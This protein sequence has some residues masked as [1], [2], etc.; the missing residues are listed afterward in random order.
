MLVCHRSRLLS[1][2]LVAFLAAGTAGLARAQPDSTQP[3]RSKQAA[4]FDRLYAYLDDDA[5]EFD[6][7]RWR[8][9]TA[10][11]KALIPPGDVG[12]SLRHKTLA[13]PTDFDDVKAGFAYATQALAEARAARDRA[14]EVRL[15]YCQ[16]SYRELFETPQT[17]LA[18]YEAGLALARSTGDGRLIAEGLVLRGGSYS[19]LGDQARALMDFFEAQKLF[20]RLGRRRAAEFNL[21]GIAIAYRR[22]GE[23]DKARENFEASRARS[24][25]RKDWNSLV[26]DLL[27]LG[28]VHEDLGEAD[29]ALALYREA[30]QLARRHSWPYD[31]SSSQLGI[32]GALVLK[33]D[34]A[35]ALRMADLA[36]KG[37]AALS[38]TSNDGMIELIR[39]RARAGLGQHAA[40]LVHFDRAARDFSAG[41]N[42]RYL[43][44]LY[45]ERAASLEATGRIREAVAD[46]K[47][48]LALREVLQRKSGNQR[49]HVLRH[50]FEAARRDLDNRR[51]AHEKAARARQ[52]AALGTV[53]RWQWIAIGVGALLLLVL[54][55][56]VARQLRRTRRLRTLALTDELTGVANRRSIG[57]FAEEAFALAR[58]EGSGLTVL[59]VDIDRFKSVNDTHGHF[60]GD[61]VLVRVAQTCEA[62]L[63]PSDRLGRV[64]GEEFLVLLP[65]TGLEAALPIAERLRQS[66]RALAFD[67]LAPG[68]RVTMSLG[69]ASLEAGDA[70]LVDLLR[71]ADLALYRAKRLGRDRVE[72]D[73]CSAMAAGETSSTH[74]KDPAGVAP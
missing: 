14:A 7:A 69:V 43:A 29:E 41:G 39:G 51:L 3:D 59:S 23:Y 5:T 61:E 27:Q 26:V 17:G 16:S 55:A 8:R 38:D 12:R 57:L 48:L 40:A 50:Q 2:L 10:R 4:A 66:T 1:A 19:L 72:A 47:R 60:A 25:E 54:G 45:P 34:Y 9:D 24:I 44:M 56:L 30:E 63:R 22:M 33:H 13:C 71:R 31:V 15:L 65:G 32:A 62:A 28:F 52:V 6:L 21:Q 68:L 73:A 20:E 42:E 64:G 35:E 46:I 11:L 74:R 36:Q 58:A 53:R 70:A 37:F 18:G 49:T 67:D